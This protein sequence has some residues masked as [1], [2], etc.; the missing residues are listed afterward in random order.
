MSQEFINTYLP[1]LS[2]LIGAIVGAA[3][4]LIAAWIQAAKADRRDRMNAIIDLAWREYEYGYNTLKASG[5]GGV[6]PPISVYLLHN[7]KL[8]DLLESGK[9]D[10]EK[11][12]NLYEEVKKI[13]EYMQANQ[14]RK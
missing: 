5:R 3:S 7:L 6:V 12:Q 8:I 11:L 13:T 9:V 10:Q 4:S 1:L 2:G 14:P